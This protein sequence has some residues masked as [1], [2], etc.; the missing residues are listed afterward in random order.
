MRPDVRFLR[1]FQPEID[2]ANGRGVDPCG[3]QDTAAGFLP[4]E[5]VVEV[6]GL[7]ERLH[8]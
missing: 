7:A 3:E 8:E 1:R 6:S 5:P 4:P 2:D